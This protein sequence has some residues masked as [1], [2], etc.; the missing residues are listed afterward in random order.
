MISVG[1][2]QISKNVALT[3]QKYVP[4]VLHIH[5]AEDWKWKNIFLLFRMLRSW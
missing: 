5:V 3:K 4:A 2:F 1:R